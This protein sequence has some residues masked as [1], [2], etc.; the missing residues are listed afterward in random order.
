LRPVAAGRCGGI[1]SPDR[2][3][4][5]KMPRDITVTLYKFDE[6]SPEAKA[7]ACDDW[8][9]AVHG[10]D[11][12]DESLESIKAFCA[13]FDIELTDWT[14]GAFTYYSYRLSDYGNSNIRGGKLSDLTRENRSEER[15]VGKA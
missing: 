13:Q 15:R 14:I 6:L 8:R 3:E 11:W 2:K 9:N 4:E 7:R 12:G 5:S 1:D 10:Y